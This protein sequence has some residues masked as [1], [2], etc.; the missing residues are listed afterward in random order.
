M[1]GCVLSTIN[2]CSIEGLPVF[3]LQNELIDE[4][5]VDVDVVVGPHQ[6]PRRFPGLGQRN[7]FCCLQT[8]FGRLLASVE[9]C[10]EVADG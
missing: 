2:L 10:I 4:G 6:E 1:C 5:Q 9:S 8:L 3:V 7:W